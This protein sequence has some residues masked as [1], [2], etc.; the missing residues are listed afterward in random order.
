MSR[1]AN[2]DKMSDNDYIAFMNAR[3][4]RFYEAG[5]EFKATED[6]NICTKGYDG[7]EDYLCLSCELDQLDEEGY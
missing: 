5:L 4:R 3:R 2:L 1:P 7:Q 6:C